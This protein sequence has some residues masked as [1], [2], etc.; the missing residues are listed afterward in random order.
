M[1]ILVI[2]KAGVPARSIIISPFIIVLFSIAALLILAMATYQANFASTTIL[3]KDA[4]AAVKEVDIVN[5]LQKDRLEVEKLKMQ[6][7]EQ[8]E[9]LTIQ[10]AKMQTQLIQLDALGEKLIDKAN[11]DASS[12]N[13]AGPLSIGGPVDDGDVLLAAQES[14]NVEE[15]FLSIASEIKVKSEELHI[16]ETLLA[17]KSIE[18][19]IKPMGKPTENGWISSY[20]GLRKDPFSGYITRHKGLDIAAKKGDNI[21][22]TAS[23]LVTW[24]GKKSGYGQLIEIKHSNNLVT[25]YGHCKETLVEIGQLIK[26]G[27]IIGKVGSSGRS[28]GPHVHYEVIKNGQKLNPLKY[29]RQH[30]IKTS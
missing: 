10:L 1:H 14:I 12:F 4:S 6:L 15:R 8:T 20:F 22:A 28:T 5:L 3:Q 17:V 9:V 16:L 24:V 11:L 29:V 19:E 23:G 21:I 18:Q 7:D 26:Q 27:D 30:R 2:N 25:R 13:F